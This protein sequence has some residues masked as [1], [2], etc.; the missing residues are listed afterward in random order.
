[1]IDS[2]RSVVAGINY[3]A[4]DCSQPFVN[5]GD[6]SKNILPLEKVEVRIHDA[7]SFASPPRVDV[8]GF[9]RVPH[10]VDLAALADSQDAQA[11]YRNTLLPLLQ[12]VSNADE[13]VIAPFCVIRRQAMSRIRTDIKES[14][15]AD[16]AHWDVTDL[17]FEQVTD[18]FY[19]RP[20]KPGVR[21]RALYNTWK[22]LSEAPTNLPLAMCDA[23]SVGP[24]DVVAGG[25]YFPSVDSI[26]DTGFFHRNDHFRWVY[27][28]KLTSDDLLIFKQFD[29]DA[30]Q[31]KMVPHSAF[32]DPS[33]PV[34]AAPRISIEARC[35][36]YWY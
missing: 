23:R 19:A 28:S 5:N 9:C 29:T 30:T 35:M 25:A 36:A 16:F 10:K 4:S 12:E 20:S 33:A 34:G 31:P 26:V 1:M 17:G 18:H 32:N 7:D 24:A 27:Y 22:L 15:G 14:L 3:V 11:A 6:F 8:E 21:R 13:L 2:P